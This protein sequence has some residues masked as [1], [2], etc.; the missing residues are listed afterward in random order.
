[1]R[2]L[3]A[4]TDRKISVPIVGGAPSKLIEVNAPALSNAESPIDV[5]VAG[6][7][8]E[9]TFVLLN[10]RAPIDCRPV[11]RVTV[12]SGLPSNVSSGIEVTLPGMVTDAR[13]DMPLTHEASNDV[14][15]GAKTTDVTGYGAAHTQ[16]E[17]A[18]E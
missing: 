13:E 9:V 2:T 3:V 11:P 4:G 17:N 7:S 16:Q 12:V 15:P 6:M 5:T 14:V 18:D 10:A 8:I 1:M